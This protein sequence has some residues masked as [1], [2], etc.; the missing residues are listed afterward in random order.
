MSKST[1]RQRKLEDMFADSS[2]KKIK[3]NDGNTPDS[4]KQT[5]VHTTRA[6]STVKKIAEDD[7]EILRQFD[8]DMS[9]GPCT[10]ISRFDRYERAVRHELDPPV[11]VLELINL[12]PN[13]RQITHRYLWR[14]IQSFNKRTVFHQVV[15]HRKPL[16]TL[17]AVL[18]LWLKVKAATQTED[19]NESNRPKNL[20]AIVQQ[21]DAMFDKEEYQKAYEYIEQNKNNELFHNHY[22]YWRVA[23]IFY[24]LSLVTKD[25]QLK[26]KL[27][28]EGYEQA[29]LALNS[30][31]HIY[32]VHKWYGILLNE[33]CQYISTDEQIRSAYEVLD[34]FEE[35][36]RLNPQDPTC[37]YLLG[38][39]YWEVSQLSGWKR[40]IAKMI[41]GELP[42]GTVHD[43]LTKFLL[44]EQI[45]PGFYSKN[46]L[47]LIKC[48]IELNAKPA[49]A[50]FA[51][52]LLSRE[53]KTQEDEE[54][55]Q[56]LLKLMPKI[57]R[58]LPFA[59]QASFSKHV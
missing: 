48:Y 54:V 8:L 18:P 47:M 41:Y 44:A 50:E 33:R 58:L 11:R 40:R 5:V 3:G 37:Y 57:E 45:S 2:T 53:R 4:N 36:V 20:S 35:A 42:K 22:I 28:E 15:H 49:A 1:K 23:R 32:S 31:N 14:L 52:V 24:K 43:A 29:K 19:A 34:H 51:K 9:F 13:D 59:P 17:T 55:H 16:L 38:S 30:G 39:W 25:K 12:Y 21:L 10:G 56:E 26:K 46:L 6:A 7:L 27:V